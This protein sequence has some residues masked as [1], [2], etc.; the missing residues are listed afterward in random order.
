MDD[1]TLALCELS[2]DL[3]YAKIPKKKL[4]YYI[5]R[6]LES[7]KSAAE[8]YKGCD[9]QELYKINNISIK[10]L[11]KSTEHFGVLLRGSAVLSKKECSVELYRSSIME[12]AEHSKLE[13][14][15]LLDYN[16]ALAIHLAHEFYHF[17]EYVSGKPISM[18]LDAVQT[19]DFKLFTRSAHVRRCE[20]IAAHAFAK[21]LLNLS[22]LPN[23]YDYLYLIDC[24]KMTQISFDN[25]IEKYH[26]ILNLNDRNQ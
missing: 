15:N 10:Y 16:T 24:G 25:M 23:Y 18:Q 21:E 8:K 13:G 5:S 12:L 17:L 1:N 26:A 6:S 11:D 14:G 20:E 3:V 19:F 22:V 7:G 4:Q 2:N 9:I